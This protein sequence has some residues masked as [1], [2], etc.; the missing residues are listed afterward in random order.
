MV[1]PIKTSQQQSDLNSEDRFWQ[2]NDKDSMLD[3]I[4]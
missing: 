3:L 1:S 2:V 4:K